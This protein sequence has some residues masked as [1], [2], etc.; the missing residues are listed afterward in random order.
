MGGNQPDTLARANC[1]DT[2]AGA[3]VCGL[4]VNYPEKG[5][6]SCDVE[7]SVERWIDWWR[8]T[9]GHWANPETR[10]L[11]REVPRPTMVVLRTTDKLSLVCHAFMEFSGTC[12]KP[13]PTKARR[14]FDDP[15]PPLGL[16]PNEAQQLR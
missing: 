5:R 16:P 15:S 13:A 9:A 14:K 12:L 4:A 8:A 6:I 10:S 7:R 1:N 11:P 2:L 3:P